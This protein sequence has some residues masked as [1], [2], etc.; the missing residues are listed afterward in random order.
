MLE[1]LDEDM[2]LAQ[3]GRQYP[4]EIG[5]VLQVSIHGLQ[6]RPVYDGVPV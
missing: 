5:S 1:W 4:K 2:I 6:Q 3:F